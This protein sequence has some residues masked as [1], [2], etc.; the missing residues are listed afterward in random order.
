MAYI[1][2]T[3]PRKRGTKPFVEQRGANSYRLQCYDGAGKRYRKT[4]K[5]PDG[6]TPRKL[7]QALDKALAEFVAEVGRG[8]VSNSTM[9]LSEWYDKWMEDYV[10]PKCAAKTH[11][12]WEK[13]WE[14]RINEQLGHLRVDKIT[15]ADIDKFYKHLQ[16]DGANKRTGKKLS[17]STVRKYHVMLHAMFR[18]AVKKKL[19]AYNP[20]DASR[21]TAPPPA[22]NE[23]AYWLE[24]EQVDKIA[25]A[26]GKEALIFRTMV[27]LC[28]EAGIRTGE[29][30]GLQWDDFKPDKGIL[31]VRRTLQY[32]ARQGVSVREPKTKKS[33]RPIA[34]SPGM[35]ALLNEWRTE[36][37][38]WHSIIGDEWNTE[39]G[40]GNK[41]LPG[42][43]MWTDERGN[44]RYPDSFSPRFKAFLKRAGFTPEEVKEIT[45]HTLRHSSASLLIADNA[46]IP[47]VGARLGHAQTSTT[48]NIYAHA[49]AEKNA[50]AATG[51]GSR[52]FKDED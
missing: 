16:S 43:W 5:A 52:L 10:V 35:V 32:I 18:D 36:Q 33:I 47:T 29:L 2:F 13:L 37:T 45:P 50:A 31:W 6:L 8:E 19:A 30:H 24:P 27:L 22:D 12:E 21:L 9:K 38:R 48:L 44:P 26:L 7:Q 40:R 20:C 4:W 3:E 15:P 23:E 39:L 1:E 41:I 14:G 28:L 17:A 34:L 42:D 11:H 25:V 46:D 51:L 49:I